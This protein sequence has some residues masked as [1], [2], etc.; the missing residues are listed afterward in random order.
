MKAM[1]LVELCIDSTECLAYLFLFF[2]CLPGSFFF[3]FFEEE[4][5]RPL[6]KSLSL[7]PPEASLLLPF[8]LAFLLCSLAFCLR[9]FGDC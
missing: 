5:L 8:W 6:R 9:W 1:V 3:L 4:E 7:E 2:C